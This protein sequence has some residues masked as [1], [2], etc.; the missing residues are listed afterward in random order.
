M[1]KDEH[2][3]TGP[4]DD[5]MPRSEYIAHRAALKAMLRIATAI[6]FNA[7][8]RPSETGRQYWSSVL[9]TKL[10][11][12][13]ITLHSICPFPKPKAHWDLAAV[14]GIVRSNVELWLFF[15]WLCVE[16]GD[17][18]EWF[19]RIR[20]FWLMDNRARYRLVT[21]GGGDP[22]DAEFANR[23]SEIIAQLNNS[24]I[25]NNL[26]E[27]RKAELSRGDKLPF[28]QDEVLERLSVNRAAFRM[29]YRHMSSFVHTGP[30]S[31]FRMAEHKRGNG[32]ENPY[33]RAYM[34]YGLLLATQV[35]AAC[36][37]EM[38]KLHPQAGIATIQK[39]GAD[40]ITTLGEYRNVFT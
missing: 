12:S 39:L 10:V 3:Y 9:F 36:S 33:D 30:V 17:D 15:H 22:N 27:K 38:M 2:A 23:Q 25:F 16:T 11:V 26:S 37:D 4:S 31:V 35:L 18:D 7:G 1:E 5:M 6:S 28:I 13:S 29:T 34:G 21:D 8:G 14:S 40:V 24:A 20:L 32:N 19:F